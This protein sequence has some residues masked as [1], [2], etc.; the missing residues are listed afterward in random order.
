M[1]LSGAAAMAKNGCCI[2][3]STSKKSEREF[4]AEAFAIYE[5]GGILK[6]EVK[7]FIKEMLK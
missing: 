4:F 1:A 5:K 2:Y 3:Q 7:N 6:D